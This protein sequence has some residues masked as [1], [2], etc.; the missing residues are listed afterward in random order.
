MHVLHH[1]PE[2]GS[3]EEIPSKTQPAVLE[4]GCS[5]QSPPAAPNEGFVCS[6]ATLTPKLHLL[7]QPGWALPGSKLSNLHTTSP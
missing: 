5:T 6:C 3:Q 4:W 1:S 7:L 2:G